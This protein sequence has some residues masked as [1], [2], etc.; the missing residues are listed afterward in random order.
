MVN[1]STGIID[2]LCLRLKPGTRIIFNKL[3]EQLSVPMLKRWK[4]DLIAYGPSLHEED[5]YVVVRR[6][7]NMAE[8]KQSQDAYYESDEWKKGPRET[9]L[10]FIDGYTSVVIPENVELVEG[11]RKMRL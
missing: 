8:R 9:I 7:S 4:V 1:T 11:F 6:Y 2:I 5:T 10:A 3:Y